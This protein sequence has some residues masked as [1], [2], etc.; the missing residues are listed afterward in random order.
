MSEAVLSPPASGVTVTLAGSD[1]TGGATTLD[2]VQALNMVAPLRSGLGAG[3]YQVAWHATAAADG[4]MTSGSFSFRVASSSA[5][6]VPAPPVTG[7]TNPPANASAITLPVDLV[8]DGSDAFGGGIVQVAGAGTLKEVVIDLEGAS[9][10]HSFTVQTCVRHPG[11]V[12]G[13][14]GSSISTDAYGNYYGIAEWL[15]SSEPIDRI[16]LTSTGDQ[17]EAYLAL[18]LGDPGDPL[19]SLPDVPCDSCDPSGT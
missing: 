18:V 12:L 17:Q 11:D 5:S 19:P 4:G 3:L 13:C 7:T 1:V 16:R 10:S 6:A 8:P 9:P 15:S 2:P 14:M